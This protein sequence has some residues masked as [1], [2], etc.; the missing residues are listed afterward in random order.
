MMYLRWEGRAWPRHN[1]SSGCLAVRS[2]P[3]QAA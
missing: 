2:L 1:R 3:G